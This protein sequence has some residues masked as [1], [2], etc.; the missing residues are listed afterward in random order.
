M[1]RVLRADGPGEALWVL[2][3]I[4]YQLDLFEREVD[5]RMTERLAHISE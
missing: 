5:R 3:E 2:S 4:S 1:L